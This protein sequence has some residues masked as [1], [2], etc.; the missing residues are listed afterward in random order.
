MT[1]E[2]TW[3]LR[4]VRVRHVCKQVQRLGILHSKWLGKAFKK[5]VEHNPKSHLS[6][7]GQIQRCSNCGV[8]GYKSRGCPKLPKAPLS[9]K[10]APAPAP[11]IRARARGANANPKPI[12]KVAKHNPPTKKAAAKP[13][14]QSS[15]Q[16]TKKTTS[17]ASKPS[18]KPNSSQ[19]I[20]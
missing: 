18:T 15:S 10:V 20:G 14:G 2:D 5:K 9:A 17:A 6:R 11:P 4:S 8:A 13:T 16:P 19:P 1:D 12:T 7:V 3:Q